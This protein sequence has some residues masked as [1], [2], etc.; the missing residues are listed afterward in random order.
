MK[1]VIQLL[2]WVVIFFLGYMVFDAVYEPVQ[3]NEV[4][5]KRYRKV[6]G[7]LIDIRDAQLAYRDVT[8][9]FT[10]DFDELI[11]FIDTAEFTLTQRR[12]TTVLDEEFKRIY[13]V[14]KYVEEVVVDTLGYASV[15]DSLFGD[16]DRYKTMMNVPIE[17]VDAKFEL[18]AGT[19]T[20]NN[21]NIPVFE[22]KVAKEILLH[23]QPHDLVVQEK[24]VVS[25]DQ[26][27]GEFIRVGSME[28]V[29]TNG[30]WP[31]N[32]GDNE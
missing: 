14:D 22:A 21:T 19:V 27:N 24:Q 6:I 11:R 5:E 4:K 7:N 13:K 17:G 15:K 18:Q 30:N 29:N 28:E 8:G 12:D 3:F 26:V 25:V 31:K 32:Y 16:S 10:G 1:L 2:L 23:D 9:K 20:K